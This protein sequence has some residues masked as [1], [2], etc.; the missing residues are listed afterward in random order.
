MRRLLM[1]V[2]VISIPLFVTA[3]EGAGL[4]T[5]TADDGS[6]VVLVKI[7]VK[8]V[9]GVPVPQVDKGFFMYMDDTAFVYNTSK[10]DGIM[11]IKVKKEDS[12]KVLLVETE[13]NMGIRPEDADSVEK[14]YSGFKKRVSE[15]GKKKI[16]VKNDSKTK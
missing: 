1:V 4:Y 7:S 11:I 13:K 2:M 12:E 6:I 10:T 9:K 16:R 15:L 5:S 14:Q 3:G 8:M